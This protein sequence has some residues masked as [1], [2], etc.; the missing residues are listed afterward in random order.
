LFGTHVPFDK[1]RLDELYPSHGRYM[2]AVARADQD[3]VRAGYISAADALENLR[4]A[5]RPG[6]T[7]GR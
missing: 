1:A 6:T 2:A 3:N 7:A 4:Q 5:A